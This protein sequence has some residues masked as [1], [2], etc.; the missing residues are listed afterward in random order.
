[1]YVIFDIHPMRN[2]YDQ[3]RDQGFK[4]FAFIGSEIAWHFIWLWSTV[5]LEIMKKLRNMTELVYKV[6]LSRMLLINDYWCCVSTNI[7]L[8]PKFGVAFLAP[9]I[10]L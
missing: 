6:F 10:R 8:D 9:T 1:M 2:W 4:L 7:I 3:L 5:V